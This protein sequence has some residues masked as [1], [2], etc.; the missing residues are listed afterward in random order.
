MEIS[1]SQL[2]EYAECPRRYYYRYVEGRSLPKQSEE[3]AIGSAFHDLLKFILSHTLFRPTPEEAES[4]L[5][6]LLSGKLGAEKM[7]E[8]MELGRK[9]IANLLNEDT[10]DIFKIEFHFSLNLGKHTIRGRMD[11]VDKHNNGEVEIVEYKLHSPGKW[12]DN[13]QLV[14]YHLAAETLWHPPSIKLSIAS[15][16]ENKKESFYLEEKEVME[17]REKIIHLA[18]G[19]DREDFT[20]HRGEHCFKCPFY[21]ICFKEI[22]PERESL[23]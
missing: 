15:F 2:A 18:S 3:M 11:R 19:I 8:T 16:V 21:N 22:P 14:L 17:G 23:L 10:T 1:Y 4:R 9:V 20:P 7:E 6:S 5:R 13:L 12:R